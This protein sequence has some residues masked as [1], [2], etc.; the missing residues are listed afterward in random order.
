[1]KKLPWLWAWLW[2]SPLLHGEGGLTWDFLSGG[3]VTS[4]AI[5][6][7]GSI[8]AGSSDLSL[9]SIDPATGTQNWQHQAG[10]V[11]SAPAINGSGMAFAAVRIRITSQSHS[12]N[13]IAI[14]STTGTKAW[15]VSLGQAVSGG[16]ISSPAIAPDGTLVVL[17]GNEIYALDPGDG[18]T[19]WRYD[20]SIF[21]SPPT[22]GADGTVYLSVYES[23]DNYKV[24]ALSGRTGQKSGSSTPSEPSGISRPLQIIL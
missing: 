9:Y 22:I 20:S 1:M 2:V 14:G 18:S 15:E 3:A 8:L 24:I 10:G 13:V 7:D 21:V 16:R 11:V 6:P 17:G 12:V 23:G 4:P 19:K 5:A